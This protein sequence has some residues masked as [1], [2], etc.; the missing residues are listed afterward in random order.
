MF[1][2]RRPSRTD[3]DR[4][5]DR[6]RELPMSYS[7][8]GILDQPSRG[9]LVGHPFKGAS[10]PVVG[11]PF[12]GAAAIDQQDVVI[13]RGGADFQRARTA[14]LTWT[15]F[16][17]G[18]V[19]AFPDRPRIEVGTNVAVLIRHLG[20]WSLNGARVLDYTDQP[21]RQSVAFTYGT[22]TNHAESGEELFHVFVDPQS[23]DV[24]YKIRVISWPQSPL[25]A[26][27]QPIV[28][29]LQERFRKDSAA[30]M[31]RAARG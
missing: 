8:I 20:H 27:G 7:P 21:D 10:G 22:L 11:R 12:K 3:I 13:G 23:G 6:S 2:L 16:D 24:V 26:I 15:H 4:F 25:A 31:T 5:L 19:E 30:A 14:L 18:W 29:V 28:R 9:P 1:L 17:L